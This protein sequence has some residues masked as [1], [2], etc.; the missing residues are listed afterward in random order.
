MF[1]LLE[2]SPRSVY[3]GVVRNDK[4]ITVVIII[5]I[6]ASKFMDIVTVHVFNYE[7]MIAEPRN[8]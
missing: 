5:A 1:I 8:V 2:N 3:M 6:E 7:K 4:K